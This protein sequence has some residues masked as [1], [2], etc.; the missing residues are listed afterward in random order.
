MSAN[1]RASMAEVWETVKYLHP[2]AIEILT[3][4]FSLQARQEFLFD[5]IDAYKRAYPRPML[6]IER[7]K[8]KNE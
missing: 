5:V 8:N 3:T 6:K 4:K 7:E 1:N 2:R